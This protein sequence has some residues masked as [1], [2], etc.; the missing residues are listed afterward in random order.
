M[1]GSGGRLHFGMVAGIKSERW[2]TSNRN[3]WPDCVGIRSCLGGRGIHHSANRRDRIPRRPPCQC[4]WQFDDRCEGGCSGRWLP[5]GKS[6]CARL[7]DGQPRREARQSDCVPACCTPIGGN[8]CGWC[9]RSA[10][11]HGRVDFAC[12]E[13]GA[14]A[15]RRRPL[16]SADWTKRRQGWKPARAETGLPGS[17]HDSPPL[18]GTV[19]RLATLHT[20]VG[21]AATGIILAASGSWEVRFAKRIPDHRPRLLIEHK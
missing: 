19:W 15:P 11:S 20:C 17:V 13:R 6:P 7:T 8:R 9:A 10:A 4:D 2:P 21:R 5:R 14:G 18:C 12:G 1:I 3:P 16:R